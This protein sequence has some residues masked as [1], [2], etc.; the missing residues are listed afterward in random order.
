MTLSKLETRNHSAARRSAVATA[1]GV[2]L[3][4]MA[5][6]ASLIS[7]PVWAQTAPAAQEDQVDDIVVTALKTGAQELDRVP[8][9]IQAFSE[10]TLKDRGV[11]DGADLMQLIPGAS[12]AQEIGAGYRVFSFRGSG[13]GGPVGDGMIGYYLDDTPFGVPNFQAAPPVQYFDL[14]QVEV[15]RGPQ[16]TLYGSGSM[17]GT[18]IYRTRNPT[19]D[20]FTAQAEGEIS[21]TANASDPNY[22]IA[23][24]VSI[25]IVEDVLGIRISGG[26][27]YRQGYND[28]YSGAPTGTPRET[29]ANTVV[30]ED[31]QAVVLWR[32]DADTTVRLRAWKFSTDQDYLNVM[33]SIDPP[34]ASFQGSVV[35]FDRRRAEYYSSTITHEFDSFTLTNATSYQKSLPGGFQVGLNLGAPL[36]IGILNNGG[37]ADSFVN[38]FRLATSG[39][40][41]L[42]A[43][44]GV[45]YQKAEG[46]YTFNIAFP[47]LNLAGQTITRTENASLFSE[48]SYDL[49]GGKL[50]PLFGLRYFRDERSSDSISNGVA[51]SSES[52]P[53]KVTWRAN[54]AYYPNDD[55]LIFLSA[56]TGFRS[57]ILQSQA[58]ANAV[59]ADGVPSAIALTPDELLNLEVG[60]KGTLFDGALRL[61]T[62]VYQIEYTNLQ[63]AFNTSIGLAAFANLGDTRTRGIDIEASWDTPVEGLTLGVV[64]NV[65]DS[66]FT[67]VSPQFAAANPRFANGE[68]LINTPPYNW[69]LDANYDRNFG[70]YDFFA[71]AS[72]TALGRNKI[73][74]ATVDTLDPYQLY[75]AA[76]G[77]R[78]DE[79]ELR[80]YG[81][82]LSDERG[83]TAANG[84]TLLAGPRPRTVGVTLRIDLN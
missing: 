25:P 7:A 11:R 74:D 63:S 35:G 33:N 40:G 23:G 45:F 27:D 65:N 54:L 36:G 39:E 83:P 10:E 55:W 21:T 13:A 12:Q 51:V 46:L 84:P 71:N 38:E 42:H 22:R 47:T 32:P 56:G 14:E 64:G 61:A 3:A 53:D 72:M 80:L 43:V 34:F 5:C 26:Y 18:I 30:A 37:D 1:R 20:R 82:N 29:D 28:I 9:A 66:K 16:G 6:A 69:R 52:K 57:G 48:I 8:L 81:E 44:G 75:R 77:I 31:L 62:S 76:V 4:A 17:G 41:P 73:G 60:T 59:I 70:K 24:A 67:D 58:Q 78:W 50:V 79:Y 2:S 49:M 15:L 19:L 68:K